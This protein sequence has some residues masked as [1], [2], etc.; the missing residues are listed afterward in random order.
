[1]IIDWYSF[2]RICRD[3]TLRNAIYRDESSTDDRVNWSVETT[4]RYPI[5]T[6]CR[7]ENRSDA[8][9]GRGMAVT[10]DRN[11]KAIDGQASPMRRVGLTTVMARTIT[12]RL[13]SA[14]PTKIANNPAIVEESINCPRNAQLT[15][16]ATT[17]WK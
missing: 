15:I 11:G 6:G 7:R 12:A 8:R 1:M 5:A 4:V 3:N 16:V 2:L 9:S 10:N 13:T 14:N 17:G